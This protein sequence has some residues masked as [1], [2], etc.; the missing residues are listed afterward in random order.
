MAESLENKESAKKCFKPSNLARIYGTFC[1]FVEKNQLESLKIL[2]SQVSDVNFKKLNQPAPLVLALEKG[3]HEIVELLLSHGADL[4]NE[5][6]TA[7]SGKI[8]QT[9]ELIHES[10]SQYTT[11]IIAKFSADFKANDPCYKTPLGLACELG[12][13]KIASILLKFGAEVNKVGHFN[14]KTPLHVACIFS[15]RNRDAKVIKLLLDSG[16][17]VNSV[18]GQ[19]KT[20]FFYAQNPDIAKLLIEHG[21]ILNHQNSEGETLLF[22]SVVFFRDDFIEFLLKSGIDL[23]LRDNKGRSV[24]HMAVMHRNIKALKLMLTDWDGD[25]NEERDE[26]GETPQ[27]MIIMEWDDSGRYDPRLSEII[28]VLLTYGATLDVKNG[29]GVTPIEKLRKYAVRKDWNPQKTHNDKKAL[30]MGHQITHD[31]RKI[32]ID[33]LERMKKYLLCPYPRTD[34]YDVLHFGRNRAAQ[35]SI[36][37]NFVKLFEDFGGDF[38][39]RFP[40]FGLRLNLRMKGGRIRKPLIELAEDRMESVLANRLPEHCSGKIFAYLSETQLR[41]FIKPI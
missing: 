41:E 31:F 35:F 10:K 2:C 20:P 25:L 5:F 7:G 36:N 8:H 11:Q 13:W 19:N 12:N 23:N 22:E 33:E 14:N 16:A 28:D 17:D 27:H 26:L 29:E 21:A 4:N 40:Y 39:K 3:F 32:W 18:D 6:A 1:Y 30:L 15:H 37:D 24:F 34:L 38:T 9:L